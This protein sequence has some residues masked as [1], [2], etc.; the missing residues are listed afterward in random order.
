MGRNTPDR[1]RIT[2]MGRLE[3]RSRAYL[4]WLHQECPQYR[5]LE[6]HHFARHVRRGNDALVIALTREAHAFYEAN[7]SEE[8]AVR[9][10]WTEWAIVMFASFLGRNLEHA[11]KVDWIAH[12]INRCGYL[13]NLGMD[14]D[15]L[16]DAVYKDLVP[17]IDEEQRVQWEFPQGKDK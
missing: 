13:S 9:G 2:P 8:N 4:G 15:L 10:G 3:I 6:L 1:I 16:F 12:I 14:T 7:P 11:A 5:S 17:M